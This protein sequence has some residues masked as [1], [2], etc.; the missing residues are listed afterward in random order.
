[1]E[2]VER[3]I[4]ISGE[5]PIIGHPVYIY[6]FSNCNL[7]CN[8]CDTIYKNEI[9]IREAEGEI[10]EDIKKVTNENP[11]IKVL[12]TG[13]EPLLGCRQEQIYY[14]I[15][16]LPQTEFFIETNGTIT[17]ERNDLS[18]CHF[19][20]DCKS[21]SAGVM[22]NF[23]KSNLT[24]LNGEKDCIKFVV[25]AEDLEWLTKK[26]KDVRETNR[27]LPL[28]VSAVHGELELKELAQFII[29][30]KLP[31]NMSIQLHKMIWHDTERGV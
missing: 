31:V 1:M 5:A 18:N 25:N 7:D 9:N 27:N 29:K 19:I 28:Y 4:T 26:I 30:N 8:Y 13:G 21:P 22:E 12:F 3:F 11:H 17:I 15:K 16:S 2:I 14:I 10:I 23:S 24:L 20:C 6:R